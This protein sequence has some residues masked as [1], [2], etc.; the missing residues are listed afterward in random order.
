[1]LPQCCDGWELMLILTYFLQLTVKQDV[2]NCK[3][4]SIMLLS[5]LAAGYIK[6]LGK[7]EI[8]VDREGNY[9]AVLCLFL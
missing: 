3:S 2:S 5:A 6:T 1:M 4:T 9:N 7:R 8:P